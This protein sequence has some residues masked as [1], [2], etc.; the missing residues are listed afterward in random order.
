MPQRRPCLREAGFDTTVIDDLS[1]AAMIQALNEFLDRA[2]V[3]EWAIVYCAGHG[4]EM[5]GINYLIPS[6]RGSGPIATC[7]TKP[8]RL[9]G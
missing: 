4:L 5:N 3:A 6:M 8:C 1:R 7:R 9:G 2:A